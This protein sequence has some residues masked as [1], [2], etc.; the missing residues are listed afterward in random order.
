MH[1]AHSCGGWKHLVCQLAMSTA[2]TQC[3]EVYECSVA[4]PYSDVRIRTLQEAAKARA[5]LC[6][7]RCIR[8]PPSQRYSMRHVLPAAETKSNIASGIHS[9][10]QCNSVVCRHGSCVKGL[11]QEAPGSTHCSAA[12]PPGAASP[13]AMRTTAASATTACDDTGR[14]FG[15]VQWKTSP[16]C[17]FLD[18]AMSMLVSEQVEARRLC[19]EAFNSWQDTSRLAQRVLPMQGLGLERLLSCGSPYD[20][21][22]CAFRASEPSVRACMKIYAS[23]ACCP[24]Q[25]GCTDVLQA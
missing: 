17:P 10:M 4:N 19:S 2:C 8:I 15:S 25:P 6:M 7:L 18:A 1:P 21:Y 22:Q 11:S 23:P 13:P 12:M 14:G 20:L 5:V 16:R 24:W 3:P 9:G